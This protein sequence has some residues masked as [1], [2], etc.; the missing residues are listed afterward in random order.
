MLWS[1]PVSAG[2]AAG[3]RFLAAWSDGVSD[4]SMGQET[5]GGSLRGWRTSGEQ[6]VIRAD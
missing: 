6:I 2:G 3:G 4:A 5:A 1:P